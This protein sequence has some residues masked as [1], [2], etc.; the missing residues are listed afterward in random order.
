MYRLRSRTG[1][2]SCARS[3]RPRRR[4][5]TDDRKRSRN[6]GRD[7]VCDTSRADTQRRTCGVGYTTPSH[8]SRRPHQDID[9]IRKGR[10][11]NPKPSRKRRQGSR[12]RCRSGPGFDLFGRAHDFYSRW[13]TPGDEGVAA[14]LDRARRTLGRVASPKPFPWLSTG[15]WQV[16]TNRRACTL[17]WEELPGLLVHAVVRVALSGG[18]RLQGRGR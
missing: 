8:R 6:L 17:S 10:D 2:P 16:V 9:R 18:S 5:S 3:W 15:S 4:F 13:N 11:A 1:R 7:E 14:K 12:R